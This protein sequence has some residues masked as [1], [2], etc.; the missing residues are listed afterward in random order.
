[1]HGNVAEHP[2]FNV[3]SQRLTNVNSDFC[4]LKLN[5]TCIQTNSNFSAYYFFRFQD[6]RF[7]APAPGSYEDPRVAL[8]ALNR[9][10]G[11]KKSPFGKTAARFSN[12]DKRNTPGN[13][14]FLYCGIKMYLRNS[15]NFGLL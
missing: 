1:M 6:E 2:G 10:T 3:K 4:F 7:K 12:K 8:G 13:L 15:I 9:I 11:A 14:T 5:K